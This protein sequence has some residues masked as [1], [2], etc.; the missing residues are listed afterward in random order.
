MSDDNMHDAEDIV[1][2]TLADEDMIVD[3]ETP[4]VK[5]VGD[6]S[7]VDGKDGVSGGVSGGVSE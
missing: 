2:K 4:S 5:L 6:S 3:T 1:G 7:V